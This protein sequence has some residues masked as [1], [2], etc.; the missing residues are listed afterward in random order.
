MARFYF[1]MRTGD[2]VE[3]DTDGTELPDLTTARNEA[4]YSA[5]EI[6]A[7]AIK[8]SHQPIDALVIA[9][10]SGRELDTVSLK[11]ALPKGLC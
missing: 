7:D 8:A 10:D 2:H 9:D 4:L 6:L 3:I 1:H 5:R 11:D